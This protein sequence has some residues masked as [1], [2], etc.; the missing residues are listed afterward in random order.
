MAVILIADDSQTALLQLRRILEPLG[1]QIVTAADGEEAARALA[2]EA[3]PDLAILDVV[4][5]EP[6]GFELCRSLK[7]D[8]RT[9]TM[10]VFLL[11][12]MTREADRFWGLK[13]GADEYLTK[14]IDA[15]L[16]VE[17]VRARLGT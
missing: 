5:P 7:A 15:P 2:K 3:P 1:H 4:M 10:P 17:K 14:P 6:N 16:L 11:T 12:S 13:Q 9:Q 8:P